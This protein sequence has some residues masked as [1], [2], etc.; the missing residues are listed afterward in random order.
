MSVIHFGASQTQGRAREASEVVRR[1]PGQEDSALPL[2]LLL[3]CG[4]RAPAPILRPCKTGLGGAAARAPQAG[5]VSTCSW[6]TCS[7]PT[8]VAGDSAKG[9]LNEQLDLD[10]KPQSQHKTTTDI[11]VITDDCAGIRCRKLLYSILLMPLLTRPP[12]QAGARKTTAL[13]HTH[14]PFLVMTHA[15]SSYL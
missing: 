7:G 9:H 8:Q 1:R 2:T 11:R 5:A 4:S 6:P 13:R 14:S 12:W 15:L 10:P 3:S